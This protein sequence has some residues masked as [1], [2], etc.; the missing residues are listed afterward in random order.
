M[1]KGGGQ[2]LR[3]RHLSLLQHEV[4][5]SSPHSLPTVMERNRELNHL[6]SHSLIAQRIFDSLCSCLLLTVPITT[7]NILTFLLGCWKLKPFHTMAICYCFS[8]ALMRCQYH[9]SCSLGQLLS[10]TWA[11]ALGKNTAQ[12]SMIWKWLLSCCWVGSIHSVDLLHNGWLTCLAEWGLSKV[13]SHCMGF[14]AYASFNRF[15]P[16]LSLGN[17]HREK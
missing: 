5:H 15:E 11:Q 7:H 1:G 13:S 16:T 9:H 12:V 3:R 14:K 6:S 2:A 8:M 4:H 17:W 10:K